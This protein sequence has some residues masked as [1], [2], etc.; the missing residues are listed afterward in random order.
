MSNLFAK[1]S[2]RSPQ[3]FLLFN[4]YLMA[5]DESHP[6]PDKDNTS[7]L[8]KGTFHLPP[9][10]GLLFYL[11]KPWVPYAELV[12]LTRPIGII[13]IHCPF[14]L[15][16]LFALTIATPLPPLHTLLITETKLFTATVFL[17]GACVAYNDLADREIDGNIART[18][19]R[20]LARKAITP[21]AASMVVLVH[22]LIWLAILMWISAMSLLYAVPSLGLAAFYPYSKRVTDFTPVVLGLTMACGVFI[23]SAAM[24]VDIITLAVYEDQ[25]APAMALI[26]IYSCYAIWTTIYECVYAYQDILDDQK[27]SVRSMAVRL[28]DGGKAV[29]SV[30]AVLQVCFYAYMGKL[31]DAASWT[32]AG[33]CFWMSIALGTMIWRVDLKQ[34]D[35][36]W[37]WFANGTW[38]VGGS[39]I[40]GLV[41]QI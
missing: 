14:L 22:T 31:L 11:P 28:G 16:T 27:Y 33:S 37:W 15:G 41:S 35:H 24:N 4:L 6:G 39:M 1:I 18:Q 29:L 23:G 8:D 19:L 9:Q 5:I 20:P 7:L 3:P 21:F 12:R 36:C 26:C 38:L 34:P 32:F 40:A 2:L 25:T 17:R 10:Q 30:L 13:I